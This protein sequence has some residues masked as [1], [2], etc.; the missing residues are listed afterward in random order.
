MSSDPTPTRRARFSGSSSAAD[1]TSPDVDAA[2]DRTIGATTSLR[3]NPASS[4]S[5]RRAI[6][7]ASCTRNDAFLENLHI[8]HGNLG[9]MQIAQMKQWLLDFVKKGNLVRFAKAVMEFIKAHPW[10]LL[11]SLGFIIFGIVL[12]A[13][14]LAA[15]GFGSLGPIAGSIAAGWQ[16]TIGNVAAGSLFAFLQSVGMVHAVTIL[17]WGLRSLVVGPWPLLRPRALQPA[18]RW[19]QNTARTSWQWI[20]TRW[21]W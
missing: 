14:P 19:V 1:S 10:E 6:L 16:A 17:L 12:I 11:G 7:T 5:A 8:T 9:A 15:I 20:K 18:S 21:A 13:N 4:V 3:S 2:S